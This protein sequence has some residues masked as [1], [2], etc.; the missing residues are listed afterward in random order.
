[1]FA[2]CKSNVVLEAST[3]CRK[4]RSSVINKIEQQNKIL[5]FMK[6]VRILQ[7]INQQLNLLK[8][9]RSV[10]RDWGLIGTLC[11][12]LYLISLPL[13]P[14]PGWGVQ[15]GREHRFIYLIRF[16]LFQESREAVSNVHLEHL[17]YLLQKLDPLFT[18]IKKLLIQSNPLK[19]TTKV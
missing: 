9:I 14:A 13:S 18:A 6:C 16:L 2:L 12:L 4:S 8:D 17:F 10:F 3:Y 19:F 5:K 7:M 1:M 11:I 15:G